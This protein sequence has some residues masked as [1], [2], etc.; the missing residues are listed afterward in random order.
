M[1]DVLSLGPFVV[2]ISLV[3]G[4]L[5][6]W[7]CDMLLWAAGFFGFGL[8]V[9]LAI[10]HLALALRLRRR[11]LHRPSRCPRP[12][13]DGA[14]CERCS[15][16][17]GWQHGPLRGHAR[18]G[19]PSGHAQSMWMVAVAWVVAAPAVSCTHYTV[20]SWSLWAFAGAVCFQRV[21]SGCH[22]GPQVVAGAL[23][24][25]LLG[26]ALAP[27]RRRGGYG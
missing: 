14:W 22:S 3:W 12:L 23:L 16:L 19:F 1:H 24:G 18:L 2:L 7:D 27:P 20:L 26:A 5:W 11:W 17:P 10:K 8:L 9:N 15:M 13:A 25:A 6:R 4:A 21:Q